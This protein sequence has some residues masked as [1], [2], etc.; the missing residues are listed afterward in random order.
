MAT[1]I[2]LLRE[3]QAGEARIQDTVARATAFRDAAKGMGV[4]VTGQFWTMGQ[5]DGVLVFDAPDAEAAAAAVHHLMAQGSVRAETLRAFD[6]AEM[7]AVLKR[8]G[9]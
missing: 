6:A 7:A 4:T 5:Y 3:T 9:A 1:Y 8:G 2:V